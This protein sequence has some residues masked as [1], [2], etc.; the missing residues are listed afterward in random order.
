MPESD[1]TPD[2]S[3]ADLYFVPQQLVMHAFETWQLLVNQYARSLLSDTRVLDK[4]GQALEG[5]MQL[6]QQADRAMQLSISALQ[7]PHKGDIEFLQQ[8]LTLLENLVRDLDDKVD[9]L[10]E[11]GQKHP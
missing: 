7:M 6:K 3:E 1:Q 10:L 5:V 11:S 9:Q 4:S 8:K 2:R